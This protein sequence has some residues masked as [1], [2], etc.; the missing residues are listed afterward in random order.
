MYKVPRQQSQKHRRDRKWFG[1]TRVQG[2]AGP[3]R[4]LEEDGDLARRDFYP[5]AIGIRRRMIRSVC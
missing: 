5:E 1:E 3:Q 2:D 4:E